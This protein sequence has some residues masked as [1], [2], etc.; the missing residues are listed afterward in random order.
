[1]FCERFFRHYNEVHRHSGIGLHTPQ[2]VHY[3]SAKAIQS[4]RGIVLDAAYA[5]HPGRFFNKAPHPALAPRRRVDQQAT[6]RGGCTEE[7]VITCLRQL[8]RFRNA[9]THVQRAQV[10][11]RPLLGPTVMALRD[12]RRQRPSPTGLSSIT[13]LRPDDRR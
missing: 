12:L 8:D 3:G 2:S 9:P 13:Q 1:M 11:P 6:P 5:A 7:S 4:R 10:R